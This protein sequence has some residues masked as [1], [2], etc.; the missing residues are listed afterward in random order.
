MQDDVRPSDSFLFLDLDI[1][2]AK[3]TA[4]LRGQIIHAKNRLLLGT[5]RKKTLVSR[6]CLFTRR[7]TPDE[8]K[9]RVFGGTVFVLSSGV[10]RSIIVSDNLTP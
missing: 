5:R 6:A 2:L 10:G 9:A 1:L 8:K 4:S 7:L 3:D